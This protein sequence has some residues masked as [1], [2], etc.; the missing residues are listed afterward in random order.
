[1]LPDRGTFSCA[2]ICCFQNYIYRH[3]GIQLRLES[4]T[5]ATSSSEDTATTKKKAS[6]QIIHPTPFDGYMLQLVR[7]FTKKM[8]YKIAHVILFPFRLVCC[9]DTENPV[10]NHG[11]Q[12]YIHRLQA[13]SGD[14]D[15]M[16]LESLYD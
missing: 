10:V 9:S 2:Y 14:M 16:T 5:S 13:V 1:M 6:F 3:V 7:D 4:I 8:R 12:E 15:D 11:V